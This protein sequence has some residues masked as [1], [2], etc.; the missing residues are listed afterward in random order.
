MKAYNKLSPLDKEEIVKEFYKGFEF[1]TISETLQVS[2]RAIAR[3][4]K[5][6]GVNTKRRN[7]YSLDEEYFS[8]INTE[9]KAYILGLIYA[10][11]FVGDEKF[12]NII[13]GL[14]K[15]DRLLLE[16]I[17]Q[18]IK[19]TGTIRDEEKS[20]GFE[21]SKPKSILNFSSKRMAEDL[22]SLGLYPRKSLTMETLPHL[23]EELIRH[24]IRGY[25]DGDGS[26]GTYVSTSYHRMKNGNLKVYGY[27]SPKCSMIGTPRFLDEIKSH[28][29]GNFVVDK[30][31][32]TKELQYI[33]CVS[34]KDIPLVF[35]YLYGEATLYLDRKFD[36]W[37]RILSSLSK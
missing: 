27:S 3:T 35:D 13:I 12:N 23:P 36:K 26:I 9:A 28:L 14:T 11:G 15:T 4:L 29:P 10:D 31:C 8:I 33:V 19:F 21:G 22:R 37:Q 32:K 2:I 25:F 7:R 24:F 17:A 6:V 18:E 16:K 34:K 20:G 5:D 30:Y 1:K